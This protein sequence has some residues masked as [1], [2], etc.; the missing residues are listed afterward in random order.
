MGVARI[1]STNSGG[2]KDVNDGLQAPSPDLFSLCVHSFVSQSNS[3]VSL[4]DGKK[5]EA[6]E[7]RLSPSLLA[8]L[9]SLHTFSQIGQA[10]ALSSNVVPSD[11]V[12]KRTKRDRAL[13]G[14]R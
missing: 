14:V 13:A 10:Y 7:G 1:A 5:A 9:Q 6:S 8:L 4:K 11:K 2:L 12:Q 3:V